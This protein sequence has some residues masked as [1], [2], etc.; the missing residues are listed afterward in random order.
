[1][2]R[3]AVLAGLGGWLPPKV[4]DNHELAERIDTTDEWIRSRTG[5]G[6]RRVIEP[7]TAT[8]DMAIAAG[9]RALISASMDPTAPGSGGP[10]VDAVVL[11]TATPDQQCPASAPQVA[12]GLGLG[13]VAAFDVNAVC[14]GFVYALATGSGLI[15]AGVAERVLVI[16]ADAF[17][18]LVHPA[19]RSTV[20]IFGDGAGAMVLRSGDG[21][22]PGAVGPY[23]LHSDGELAELLIVPAGGSKQRSSDNVEDHYLTMH[24]PAVFRQASARMSESARVVLDQAGLTVSDV[25]RFVGHQA[26]IRILNAVAK[27]LGLATDSLVVNIDKVGNTSAASIPLALVDACADETVLPGDRVLLSAFGAGLSWGSTLLRWPNLAVAALD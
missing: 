1:M 12:S 23:D 25:D 7:G 13:T 2:S 16:G 5:I 18:T 3:Q 15:S 10:T 21:D 6:Q 19:D 22:E 24:G 11:A 17:T 14:T 20:P 27:Q 8:V 9:R 4:V 26:N